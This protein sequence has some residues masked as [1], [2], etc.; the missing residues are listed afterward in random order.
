LRVRSGSNI[1]IH[2]GA[3]KIYKNAGLTSTYTPY[4][5]DDANTIVTMI[6]TW[7][8]I[9]NPTSPGGTYASFAVTAG[10]Q[11]MLNNVRAPVEL[12]GGV[13]NWWFVTGTNSLMTILDSSGIRYINPNGPSRWDGTSNLKTFSYSKTIPA[14]SAQSV[15]RIPSTAYGDSFS[16]RIR[17]H[18]IN[19]YTTDLGFSGVMEF[20]ATGFKETT[21]SQNLTLIGQTFTVTNTGGGSFGG[22][23]GTL[24][25]NGDNTVDFQ[26]NVANAPAVVGNT[27]VSVFV[28]YMTNSGTNASSTQIVGV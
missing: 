7:L 2:G 25:R 14:G 11:L 16:A 17:V 8:G 22:V 19:G 4:E 3:L 20:Q 27:I 15:F 6:D 9:A 28:D 13:G 26:L 23:T 24:L 5:V 10:A 1:A 18:L 12:N 21:T